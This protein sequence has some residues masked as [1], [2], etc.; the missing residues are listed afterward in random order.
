MIKQI[1][2]NRDILVKF[3]E[4]APL[5]NI[6]EPEGN[7]KPCVR[8]SYTKKVT[9]EYKNI[10]KRSSIQ[11][12]DLIQ[13]FTK[14]KGSSGK[15]FGEAKITGKGIVNYANSLLKR[16]IASTRGHEVKV[17]DK[18]YLE[19]VY[20][21]RTCDKIENGCCSICTC[22]IHEKCKYSTEKCPHPDG[23]RWE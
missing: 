2:E 23:S 11:E 13:Y 22:P 3:P 20:K 4:L 10:I 15:E 5:Y 19:R 1:L 17:T 9:A 14:S 7:C 6:K 21:C 8:A 16:E 18:E 12:E